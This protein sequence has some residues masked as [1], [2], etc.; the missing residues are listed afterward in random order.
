[1]LGHQRYA[2]DAYLRAVKLKNVAIL[3]HH[4]DALSEGR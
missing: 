4:F 2:G 1:M 3:L